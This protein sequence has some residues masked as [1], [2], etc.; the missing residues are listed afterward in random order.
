MISIP[1]TAEDVSTICAYIRSIHKGYSGPVFVSLSHHRLE[2]LHM[3]M[4]RKVV[5]KA[6]SKASKYERS[7]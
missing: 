7:V 2:E 3:S 1:L 6:L 5:L 4:S